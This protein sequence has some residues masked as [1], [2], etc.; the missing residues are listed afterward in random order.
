MTE[1]RSYGVVPVKRGPAGW[2]VLL[3]RH[4]AGHWSFPKGHADEGETDLEA[5]RRE[6]E[7]ETGIREYTL[8]NGAS[9]TERYWV[10]REGLRTAKTVKYFMGIVQNPEV[11]PQAEE[12]A[13]FGWVPIQAA[14]ARLTFPEARRI[15]SEV[16]KYLE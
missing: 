9:F 7:E 1:E 6:F 4:H 16:I 13:D 11:R 8:E 5:A 2:E 3:I 12:I 15:L 14:A 10:Q